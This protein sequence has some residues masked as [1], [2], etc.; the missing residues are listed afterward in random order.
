MASAAK[1]NFF[2]LSD[3]LFLRDVYLGDGAIMAG[4]PNPSSGEGF[5]Q[6]FQSQYDFDL[7]HRPIQQSDKFK[8]MIVQLAQA[9]KPEDV[10][11]LRFCY[12]QLLKASGSQ[13]KGALEILENLEEN[14]LFTC[15]NLAPLMEL[16]RNIQ[17]YDLV[18]TVENFQSTLLCEF[19]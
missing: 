2:D 19:G 12:K 9:L 6:P 14:G 11:S 7:D 15:S 10:E 1:L 13:M 4:V 16:L 17:R 8:P 3:R 5:S 18:G